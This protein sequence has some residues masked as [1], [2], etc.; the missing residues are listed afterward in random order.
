MENEL[1]AYRI[2]LDKAGQKIQDCEQKNEKTQKELEQ[3]VAYNIRLMEEGTGRR[4]KL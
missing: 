3:Q 2:E 4:K 1:R